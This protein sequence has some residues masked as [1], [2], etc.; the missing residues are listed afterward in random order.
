M[1]E[2]TFRGGEMPPHDRQILPLGRVRDK[3]SNQRVPI[4]FGGGK[5]Q[6]PGCKPVDAMYDKDSPPDR[7]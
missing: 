1:D 2:R 6:Y 3:L 4:A 5:E 7:F